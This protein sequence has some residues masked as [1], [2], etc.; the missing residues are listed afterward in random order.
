V[1]ILYQTPEKKRKFQDLL[2]SSFVA[3]SL[4]GIENYEFEKSKFYLDEVHQLQEKLNIAL[5]EL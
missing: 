3:Y 4:G 1:D 2:F 5:T